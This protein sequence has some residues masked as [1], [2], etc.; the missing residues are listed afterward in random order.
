MHMSDAIRAAF[1]DLSEISCHWALRHSLFNSARGRRVPDAT[2][3][4][5]SRLTARETYLNKRAAVAATAAYPVE[6]GSLLYSAQGG[7]LTRLPSPLL[8]HV[9]F[10]WAPR[11]RRGGHA[12]SLKA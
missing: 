1:C 4:V 2:V 7:P 5:A 11:R 6:D 9:H 8:L 3:T 10:L 12:N